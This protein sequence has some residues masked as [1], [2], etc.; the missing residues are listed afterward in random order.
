MILRRWV[1]EMPPSLRQNLDQLTCAVAWITH[2]QAS[3]VLRLR[4]SRPRGTLKVPPRVS[5]GSALRYLDPCVDAN[6]ERSNNPTARSW[7]SPLR[8]FDPRPVRNRF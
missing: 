3:A 8:S 5:D 4:S 7:P 6:G 1:T 2:A